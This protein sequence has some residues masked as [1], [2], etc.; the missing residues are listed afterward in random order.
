M[1][2]KAVASV[3]GIASL[4]AVVDGG[5]KIDDGYFLLFVRVSYEASSCSNW[6][7]SQ[8]M[9]RGESPEKDGG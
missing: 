2:R 6:M 8:L 3:L 5:T 4:Q 7:V 1:E 9:G